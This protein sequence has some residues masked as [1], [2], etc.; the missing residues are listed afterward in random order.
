MDFSIITDFTSGLPGA[1]YVPTVLTGIGGVI[2]AL[3]VI[4]PLTR[5]DLDNKA[6]KILRKVVSFGG[7]LVGHKESK[8]PSN[9][10]RDHRKP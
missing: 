9:S 7:L 1:E 6:L 4:S 8:R 10:I 5:S 2:A 3:A